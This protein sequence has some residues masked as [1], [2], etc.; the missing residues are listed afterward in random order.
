MARFYEPRLGRF[1]QTDPIGT[2]DDLNLYAYVGNNP[3]NRLDPTG[4]AKVAVG[5]AIQVAGVVTDPSHYIKRV[6][7]G[8]IDSVVNMAVVLPSHPASWAGLHLE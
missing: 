8:N 4:L 6:G 2:K 3:V 7:A 1:L 5:V